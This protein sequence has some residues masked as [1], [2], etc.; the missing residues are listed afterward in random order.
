M[1][2][3]RR[4][5]LAF[6]GIGL[7]AAAIG[8]VLAP[9][10]LQSN[11]GVEDLLA[12]ELRDLE[13]RTRRISEWR[14]KVV[15]CN[16]WA[17]WCAPCREEIPML[18]SLR[19][20]HV[21]NGLEIVGIAIDTADKIAEFTKTVPI[22][23]PILIAPAAGLDLMRTLGNVAGGLPFTVVL[24][25]KGTLAHRKLGL[26]RRDALEPVLTEALGN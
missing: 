13:G 11:A 8:A 3:S 21:A 9:R 24:D 7:G 15:V 1:K 25:R 17:T 22:S 5:I 14:G 19:E 23:Y 10:L 4:E 20:K 26:L 6:A 12:M 16:F 18:V 2:P